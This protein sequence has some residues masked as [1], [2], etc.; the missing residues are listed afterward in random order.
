MSSKEEY[1]L[2]SPQRFAEDLYWKF[3]EFENLNTEEVK[4][5]CYITLNLCMQDVDTAMR[6]YYGEVKEIIKRRGL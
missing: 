2:G 6:M 5:C 3:S 4:K 1:P